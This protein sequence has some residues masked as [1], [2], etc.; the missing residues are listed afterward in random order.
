MLNEAVVAK[1]E[2]L[3]IHFHGGI[4]QNRENFITIVDVELH[5]AVLLLQTTRLVNRGSISRR[6]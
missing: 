4:E 3:S 6:S 1:F 2:V 5:Q